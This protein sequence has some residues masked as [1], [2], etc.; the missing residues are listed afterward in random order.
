MA[1]VGPRLPSIPS[2]LCLW[3]LLEPSLAALAQLVIQDGPYFT[4]RFARVAKSAVSGVNLEHDHNLRPWYVSLA[5]FNSSPVVFTFSHKVITLDQEISLIWTS[6]W[7]IGKC[8]FLFNRYY[9]L[10]VAIFNNYVLF[11]PGVSSHVS[12]I[13]LIFQSMLNDFVTL[14]SCLAFLE[15]GY[16]DEPSSLTIG[17]HWFRWQGVTGVIAFMMGE[18]IL[19][20][21][22]FAL[23]N[24]NRRVLLVMFSTFVVALAASSVIMGIAMARLQAT[25]IS[26]NLPNLSTSICTISNIQ[27]IRFLYSFWVPIMLSESLLCLLVVIRAVEHMR[28]NRRSR[29]QFRWMQN[30][31]ELIMVLIRDSILY[32]LLL[33]AVYLVNTI[34]FSRGDLVTIEAAI[35]YSVSLSC[36]MG[37]RL[38]LNVRGMIPDLHSNHSNPLAF[39]HQRPDVATTSKVLSPI[40]LRTPMSGAQRW[41]VVVVSRSEPHGDDT[42]QELTEYEMMELREMKPEV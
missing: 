37:S 3:T 36:I 22:L 38:C 7:S 13:S 15:S 11:G 9:T 31:Q 8:L 6:G 2:S 34:L 32:F 10:F 27:S 30:G 35:S 42:Q 4:G 29:E 12:R 23:Y 18:L 25:S 14:F 28:E 40:S 39:V 20:L 5:L 26:I 21:R 1:T 33:F 41:P 19:Q 24:L 16:P 17:L